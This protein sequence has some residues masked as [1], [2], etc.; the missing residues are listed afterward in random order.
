MPVESNSE[1]HSVRRDSVQL[2]EIKFTT[3]LF[4]MLVLPELFFVQVVEDSRTPYAVL[5]VS[6]VIGPNAVT[7]SK[8]VQVSKHLKTRTSNLGS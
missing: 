8:A 2:D 5:I 6:N 4:G 7:I 1:Q 3:A